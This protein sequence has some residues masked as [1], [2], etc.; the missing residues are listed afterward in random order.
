MQGAVA[1][2]EED[3]ASAS[4]DPVQPVAE[5]W[6]SVGFAV[7]VTWLSLVQQPG[8]TTYDTRAELTERPGEFLAGAFHLWHPDSNLGE[9]QNQAYGY[10]FPHGP[11]FLLGDLLSVPD[12]VVQRLW[13]ALVLVV[14][15]EGAR[16]VGGAVGLGTAGRV[17]TGLVFALAPRVLGTVGVLTGE[18]VPGA[19]MP[20]VVLPV[21]L[22][23]GGRMAPRRAAVLSGA[24][25][26]CM[27]GV[28]AVEV[29][30]SLPL[31][32]LLVGW[33]V[34]RGLV[35]R[36]FAL[37]W[38]GAVALATLWWVLPLLV[39]ARYAPS[40]YEYVESARDTTALVGW[41]EALRGA[42]Q[43]ISYVVVGGQP[44]WP[45]AYSLSTTP[46]LMLAAA[47]I[48]GIGLV[49]LVR[50]RSALRAP[51]VASVVLG[52]VALT[53]GRGGATGSLVAEPMLALLDGPLQIFRN[54]HKIDPVIRLPLAIGFAHACVLG[55]AMVVRR[56]GRAAPLRSAA[57]VL[58]ALLPLALLAPFVQNDAR[59]P[60]WTAMAD[61]WVAARDHLREA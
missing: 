13:T 49:G 16:R 37:W 4:V 27:G 8:R 22:A 55:A 48:T 44:W 58:P 25:V 9:F 3:Q 61:H 46:V 56:P 59:T 21:L 60:G 15:Y 53:I 51:L 12:W 29:A 39:L 33:G 17:L 52:L 38:A 31:A 24:A 7:L 50:L 42:T 28:N 32:I 6:F 40:F 14:A 30:G 5:R 36:L 2:H 10:L 18:T 43:W 35:P 1:R 26:V 54:V 41:S 20:W 45:A 34:Y 57:L 47:A 23:L 11:W 19:V